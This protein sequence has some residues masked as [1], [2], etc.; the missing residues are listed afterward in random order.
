VARMPTLAAKSAAKMGHPGFVV[1][2][3]RFDLSGRRGAESLFSAE[4]FP[5]ETQS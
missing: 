5:V 3:L 1:L 2:C 4:A